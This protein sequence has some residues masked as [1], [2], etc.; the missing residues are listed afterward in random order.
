[1]KDQES[2]LHSERAMS[3]AYQG[4]LG[5]RRETASRQAGIIF[6]ADFSQYYSLVKALILMRR[7]QKSKSSRSLSACGLNHDSY[8]LIN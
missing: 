2:Q 1:V 3:V 4:L 5:H 8:W 6:F 7:F